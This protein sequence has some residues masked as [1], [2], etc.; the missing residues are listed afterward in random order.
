MSAP[1]ART[2]ALRVRRVTDYLEN[3]DRWDPAILVYLVVILAGLLAFGL[4]STVPLDTYS[5]PNT[6]TDRVNWLTGQA[7]ARWGLVAAFLGMMGAGMRAAAHG[8]GPTRNTLD[9][10]GKLFAVGAAAL[11]FWGA[12]FTIW[13]VTMQWVGP[14]LQMGF[15]LIIMIG[16]FA[17]V[18][19]SNPPETQPQP[20]Q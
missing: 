4:M 9:L 20:H 18:S 13:Q 16:V 3:P 6:F 2:A 10:G 15:G 19:R 11:A 12:A 14:A 1:S 7:I 17:I 8:R 5:G